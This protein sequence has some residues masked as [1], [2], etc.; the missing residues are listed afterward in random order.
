[1]STAVLADRSGAIVLTGTPGRPPRR[2]PAPA[3]SALAPRL[4]GPT[5]IVASSASLQTGTALA[6]TVF[7]TFGPAGTAGLRFLA[8]A[9]VLLAIARPRLGGRTAKA[10]L[11]ITGFGA[12]MAAT[13]LLLYAAVARI[14]L[15][16]AVTLEFL[17]PLA[18]ALLGA[19]RRLDATWAIAAAAGVA[20]LAGGPTGS[21]IT[22]IAFALGAAVSVA[23]SILIARRLNDH[24]D[25]VDGLA[26]AV[27][28]A[29]LLTLPAGLP[30][31]LGA[32][33]LDHLAIVAAVGVLGIALPYALELSALRRVG[34]KTYS[35]LLSLD[36]AVAG[37]AGLLFLGQH[38][39]PNDLIGIGLVVTASAG[40]VTT[41][42]NS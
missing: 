3:V 18:L 32:L 40:A 34:V 17:G 27:T 13:N 2:R 1:M 24:T 10:W 21:S 42:P 41:R 9:C 31:A 37:L 33:N 19:H 7:A 14:P 6:T 38:P 35:I 11:A 26:L 39:S 15:G 29:A 30:A 16:A 12:T 5:S 4:V 36:P 20:L 25:S 23:G 22:G 8:G 28:V